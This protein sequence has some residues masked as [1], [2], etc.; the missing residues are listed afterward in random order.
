MFMGTGAVFYCMGFESPSHN[1]V[2]K[3]SLYLTNTL[4]WTKC[5]N[6]DPIFYP[7]DL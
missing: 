5:W 6:I 2:S 3:F 7:S 4:R 1:M